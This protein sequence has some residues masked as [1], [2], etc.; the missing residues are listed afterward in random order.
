MAAEAG[1]EVILPLEGTMDREGMDIANFSVDS[2]YQA[3]KAQ[4]QL[5]DRVPEAYEVLVKP[6]ELTLDFIPYQ[7]HAD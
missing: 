5:R 1:G 2:L 6:T 7:S 3:R 4:T